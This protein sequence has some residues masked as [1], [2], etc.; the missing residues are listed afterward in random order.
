MHWID[1]L[2]TVVPMVGILALAY[3]TQRFVRGVADYISAGR[4]AGRYLL[5]NAGG[6][7]GSGVCNSVANIEKFM[8]CGFV[9]LYWE[10][11]ILPLAIL[12]MITGFVSYRYRQTRALTLAQ[13]FEERYSRRFR[14]FIGF[15]IFAAGAFNYAIFPLA[16]TLFF[17]AF[18][19]LPDHFSVGG[20]TIST[21]FAIIAS[22]LALTL[23]MICF[24]GQVSLMITDCVEG[25]FS[26]LAYLIIIFVIFSVVSWEQMADVLM[27]TVPPGAS[28]TA[29]ATIAI[30]PQHSPIDPFD[31][32][33]VKDFNFF[34]TLLGLFG[35]VYLCGA[36]QGGHGFRSAARTPHE[37]RMAGILGSWRTYA[38]VL[39]LLVVAMGVMT[40]LRH[41][42][43]EKRTAPLK[44][45]IASVRS[46][47]GEVV[48]KISDA[49]PV[50]SQSWFEGKNV[51][52]VTKE[53]RKLRAVDGTEITG[54]QIQRQRQ[55]APFMA[56]ADMLPIGIKGLLL[57]VMI[58]GLFAGDGSHIISWSSVFVQ[59]VYMPMRRKP[60]T[61]RDHLH[62][63]RLAAIG[64]AAIAF[65]TSMLVPL[66]TSIW[67]WWAVTGAIYNG[68]AGA[69]LIGGLYWRRGTV[70]AAWAA[71]TI[72][73]PLSLYAVVLSNNWFQ[74]MTWLKAHGFPEFIS[75]GFWLSFFVSIVAITV[76]VS[77]SL[78][79]CRK[80]FDLSSLLSRAEKHQE[81]DSVESAPVKRS[82]HARLVG[83]DSDF[84]KSDRSVAYFVFWFSMAMFG[85]VMFML[86]WQFGLPRLVLLFG[87]S[88]ETA[89]SLP[90]GKR[91]WA[92]LWLW[93]KLVIPCL[94]AFVTLIWFSIGGI[95]DMRSFFRT[96]KTRERDEKDNGMVRPEEPDSPDNA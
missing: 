13:F 24:G 14:L 75:S 87:G 48:A 1:W 83:I 33:Q 77:V 22:Y 39:V 8:I 64:V 26:H 72:S 49:T 28:Q 9:L 55:Q 78:L 67:I 57:V 60:M 38:R 21:N 35:T 34:A 96:M 36:W 92:N 32:F 63:L 25:L 79:T 7:A 65:V 88:P 66:S 18:L 68:G 44:E 2:V 19:G 52:G 16:S 15:I 62:V 84:T 17:K 81:V 10:S 56:L 40:Y 46:P 5:T 70:Q 85:L 45:R 53:E 41:P 93:L 27:G 89:A 43:F 91:G 71:A 23:T 4:C 82:L 80:P 61:T 12:L 95:A 31:A 30:A 90:I 59:D 51:H 58:M 54:E 76:Y 42:D 86:F 94:I 74:S 20:M 11:L 69:I 37:G 47:S 50:G 73:I 6:E 3:Y 29:A